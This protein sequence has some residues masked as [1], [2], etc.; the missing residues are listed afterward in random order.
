MDIKDINAIAVKFSEDGD[1]QVYVNLHTTHTAYGNVYHRFVKMV[2]FPNQS[3]MWSIS[4]RYL[5][6]QMKKG[7]IRVVQTFSELAG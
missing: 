1:E 7:T 6:E 5:D 3:D 4:Q 2:P